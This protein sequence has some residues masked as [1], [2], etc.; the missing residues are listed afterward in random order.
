[1]AAA[2]AAAAAAAVG[3][4][5]EGAEEAEAVAANVEAAETAQA[6]GCAEGAEGAEAPGLARLRWAYRCNGGSERSRGV[7]V[8]RTRAVRAQSA[9]GQRPGAEALRRG[10]WTRGLRWRQWWRRQR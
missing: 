4:W 10:R 1:M 2:A 3:E 8:S 5:E 6:A 9:V 7:V